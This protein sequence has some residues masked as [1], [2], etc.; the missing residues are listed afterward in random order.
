MLDATQVR[1]KKAAA[2]LEVRGWDL[3]CL[4]GSVAEGL[5]F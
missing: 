5:G 3:L 1:A 2:R 4:L